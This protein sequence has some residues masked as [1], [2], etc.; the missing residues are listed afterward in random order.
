MKSFGRIVLPD[1]QTERAHK[2]WIGLKSKMS[3]IFFL[4][5]QILTTFRISLGLFEGMWKGNSTNVSEV[6]ISG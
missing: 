6:I 1:G 3:A 4:R 2:P 5:K